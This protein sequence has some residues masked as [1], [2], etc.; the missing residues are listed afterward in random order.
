[1]VAV[2]GASVISHELQVGIP[3]NCVLN[4]LCAQSTVCS[5]EEGEGEGGGG[6]TCQ[7]CAQEKK[8]KEKE[9]EAHVRKKSSNRMRP[10]PAPSS[11]PRPVCTL[12]P[13]LTPRQESG[14]VAG[15]ACQHHAPALISPSHPTAPPLK[16]CH[17]HSAAP[18]SPRGTTRA[19]RAPGNTRTPP[20]RRQCPQTAGRE[21]TPRSSGA[22]PRRRR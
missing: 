6:G 12:K 17:L 8:E 13:S 18:R 11:R 9:E 3:I 2:K 10:R 15:Q 16:V 20:P 21:W 1:V 19:S 7:L 4:Q 22:R 14:V 5:G